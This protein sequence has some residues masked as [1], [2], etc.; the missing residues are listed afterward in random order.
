MVSVMVM[1]PGATGV[2]D[3]LQAAVSA[4]SAASTVPRAILPSIASPDV[5]IN[6]A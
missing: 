2:V 5:V 3:S 4:I 6:F 1:T